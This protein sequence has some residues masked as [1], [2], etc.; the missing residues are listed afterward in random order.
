[1]KEILGHLYKHKHTNVQTRKANTGI[2]LIYM[3]VSAV[4]KATNTHFEI[5]FLYTLPG[6][7]HSFFSSKITQVTPQ[8]LWMHQST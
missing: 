6:K 5:R 1:M 3:G 7:M 2:R 8:A 4:S